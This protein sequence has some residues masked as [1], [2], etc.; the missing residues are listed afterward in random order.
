MEIENVTER[1]YPRLLKEPDPTSPPPE[2]IELTESASNYRLK[3]IQDI[4]TYLETN[5]E[6]RRS[7]SKKYSKIN[8]VLHYS[9]YGLNI[10]SIGAGIGSVSIL[11][12]VVLVPVSIILGGI[13]I[14]CGTLSIIM[15][16]LNTKTKHKQ[17]KHR[18]IYNLAETKLNTIESIISKSLRNNNISHEE[19]NL[20][21]EEQRQFNHTKE[22]IRS[23]KNKKFYG[24]EEM[25]EK[26][27]TE[28]KE[29]FKRL[30]A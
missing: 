29:S 10:I 5:S 30:L 2:Y 21:L 9:Q 27:K 8:N 16:K 26:G 3:H 23:M 6:Q 14:G 7:L 13:S 4:K 20:I 17:E 1:I 15:N 19:F 28:I 18:D 25:K 12:T 22:M 11:S 24:E